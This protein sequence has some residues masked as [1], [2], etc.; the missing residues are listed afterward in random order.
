M[1]SGQPASCLQGLVLLA[2]AVDNTQ[3]WWSSLSHQQQQEATSSGF[4]TLASDYAQVCTAAGIVPL[5]HEHS[6]EAPNLCRPVW[7]QD[8]VPQLH[9]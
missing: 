1:D 8:H 4:F 2:P 5:Q 7:W 3:H 6:L 9:P